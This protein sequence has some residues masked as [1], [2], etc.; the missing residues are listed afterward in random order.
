MSE[1]AGPAGEGGPDFEGL[2]LR[3]GFNFHVF[4]AATLGLLPELGATPDRLIR[5]VGE[6]LAPTWAGL[7]GH[8]ADAVL[9]L[10]LDNLASTGYA[11]REVQPGADEASATLDSVPLGLSAEDWAAVLQP[12][13]VAPPAMLAL[14]DVFTPLAAAAGATISVD[15]AGEALQIRVRREGAPPRPADLA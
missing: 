8:G 11:V 1:A 5:R 13:G 14:F 3:A 15:V 10:L 12:F 4:L 9:H 2:L 6:R 7:R